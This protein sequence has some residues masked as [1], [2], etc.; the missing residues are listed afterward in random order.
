MRKKLVLL[1][2][3]LAMVMLLASHA[4]AEVKDFKDFTVDVPTGWTAVD[5]DGTVAITADDKSAAITISWGPNDGK[6]V[7]EMA[8]AYS[9]ELNGSA[10][11]AD[12]GGFVF[13]FTAAGAEVESKAFVAGEEDKHALIVMTGENPQMGEILGSLQD[14]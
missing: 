10:P 7:E 9:K 2:M 1:F 8:A 3:G 11:V 14:K 5:Q 4:L 13:T 12:S 6:S